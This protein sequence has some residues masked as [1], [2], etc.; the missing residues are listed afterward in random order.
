MLAV[1]L[2]AVLVVSSTPS[3]LPAD[4]PDNPFLRYCPQDVLAY[5]EC[6]DL[7]KTVEKGKD[8]AI[9]KFIANPE[10][11]ELFLE[12]FRA[13]KKDVTQDLDDFTR[14]I[15]LM[16]PVWEFLD[17]GFTGRAWLVVPDKEDSEGRGRMI[18]AGE[19]REGRRQYCQDFMKVFPDLLRELSKHLGQKKVLRMAE[20]D[21][22]IDGM[23]IKMLK[24]RE[25]V[26]DEES[27]CF[28]VLDRFVVITVGLSTMR[29]V[30][31]AHR[32]LPVPDLVANQDFMKCYSN[33]KWRDL[34]WYMNTARIISKTKQ[35]FEETG[36]EIPVAV[37]GLVL[38]GLDTCA[39]GTSF[40]GSGINDEIMSFFNKEREEA[41][42]NFMQGTECPMSAAAIMPGNAM[43]YYS[44]PFPLPRI[45]AKIEET[46]PESLE[47]LKEIEE[48]LGISIKDQLLPMFSSDLEFFF[49]M[50]GFLPETMFSIRI[51]GDP[52]D[53]DLFL[54]ALVLM[55]PEKFS[56][57]TYNE[58]PVYLVK[59]KGLLTFSL[60]QAIAIHDGKLLVGTIPSIQDA[61]DGIEDNL[62]ANEAF[63]KARTMVDERT[64]GFFYADSA[65][66][67]VLVKNFLLPF[68]Q[69]AFGGNFD[70]TKI[71]DDSALTENVIPVSGAISVTDNRMVIRTKGFINAS[72]FFA[73][74]GMRLVSRNLTSIS[75]VVKKRR[76]MR[77]EAIAPPP[78]KKEQ[79]TPVP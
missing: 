54:Q 66:L 73:M 34:F 60:A 55:Y 70:M 77:G 44:F 5:F 53:I 43:L 19:I 13:R 27:V 41:S 33:V 47:G 56:K 1:V 25:D 52:S 78:Q 61:I 65:K 3:G 11:R 58:V 38:M 10:I 63:M 71:P 6:K 59:G 29:D 48:K 20:S 69:Q 62:A 30:L 37:K 42:L 7:R 23:S 18:M 36:V 4:A 74:A 16:K 31:Y 12:I 72:T 64:N 28:V 9:T 8:L 2:L 32:G 45:Y 39:G 51:K 35:L 26:S 75:R 68:I 40:S 49:S 67:I 24:R 14:F 21:V 50:T 46:D 17:Y 15:S 22:S 57:S 76:E 79:E